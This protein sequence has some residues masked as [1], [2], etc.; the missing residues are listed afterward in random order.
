M[1]EEESLGERSDP[2]EM[3]TG[4]LSD[5]A[6]MVTG[7]LSDPTETARAELPEVAR[8]Q[9]QM[10][11]PR[12]GAD[13]RH[14]SA[15]QPQPTETRPRSA[16]AQPPAD[17]TKQPPRGQT[18]E[19][20]VRSAVRAEFDEV[21]PHVVTALKRHDA[22]SELTRR[23]DT[24][25]KRLAER[26]TRPLIAGLKRSLNMVRRLDFDVEVKTAILGELERLLV[27][28]GY[29]E[30]GEVGEPFDPN[31]H[32][33]IAGET[34]AG[35]AVVSEVFEPGVETLGEI[36]APALVGVGGSRKDPTA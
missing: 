10:K 27:G 36:V 14:A 3:V 21:L 23:L 4:E 31:R 8:R 15:T 24:A 29:C 1:V 26:N 35:A 16:G 9:P 22:V 33:A 13:S 5:P 6:E 7:E 28:A 19:S 30:F 20:I 17:P 32:E 25:E 12:P 2:A 34:G 11:P 18:V